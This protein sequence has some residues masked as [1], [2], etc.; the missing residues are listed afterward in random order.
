VAST[1]AEPGTAAGGELETLVERRLRQIGQRFTAGRRAI[2]ELL[3]RVG[4]PVHIG[5]IADGL[6]DLPRSS[7]YRHLVD[8]ESAGVVQ[9]VAAA[10]DEFARYELA[11]AL[12]EHHHHLLCTVC[13]RVVDITPSPALERRVAA[14]LDTLAEAAGFVVE[15]HRIDVL[16]RC[17][18]C[19]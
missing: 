4:H 9:R 18:T 12:T 7:A 8:L 3:A 1:P 15:S 10:G 14:E 16:G 2:V 17:A 11:E 6:P 13:G 5:D 19:H